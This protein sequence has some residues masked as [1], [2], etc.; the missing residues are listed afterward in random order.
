MKTEVDE[1]SKLKNLASDLDKL[2]MSSWRKSD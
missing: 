1:L 2:I